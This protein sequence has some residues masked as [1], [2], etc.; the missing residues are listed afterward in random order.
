[1][2]WLLCPHFGAIWQNNYLA[3]PSHLVDL[4]WGVQNDLEMNRMIQLLAIVL[5]TT[6]SWASAWA[7]EVLP[8]TKGLEFIQVA[9]D[10][11]HFTFSNSGLRFVPW[12]FNYDHDR[13]NRLLETYWK[14]EWDTVVSDFQEMKA[15]GANTLR[16]HLQVSRFMKS[17][18]ELNDESLE[19]L[20][21]LV[22]LA[23]INGL[24]LDI[25]GLGCYDKKD[26]PQWYDNLDETRRWA[27]QARF[28]EAIAETCSNSPAIFCYDLMNEPVLSE[29]KQGRD[30]TPGAFSDRYFVQRIT[31]DFAGRSQ[32]EIAKAWVEKLVGAIRK[33]DKNHM[34][35]IG[36]I[37][38][39]LTWPGAKDVFYSKEVSCNLDFVSVHFYPKQREVKKALK[40]L[41]TYEI[42]KP[43]VIEEMFPLSCSVKELDKFIGDSKE[44]ATGWVG[45]YWGKTL[46]EYHEQ[47]S[48][49]AEGLTEDWLKYFVKKT[50]DILR[51]S[52]K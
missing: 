4:K 39:A 41:A 31:L 45:F 16:I 40:A 20:R 33:H 47:K 38:W 15:L 3:G 44:L 34:I 29:D 46:E 7:F 9:K 11:K 43:I 8:P 23:E 1:L 49:M 36:A 21:R 24:Y 35:T 52:R 10:R 18:E 32:K 14:A 13:S 2:P 19:L 6:G 5:L 48:G 26:V 22:R 25:T 50:P 37:P 51:R 27:V 30:W 17:A 12:G 28:W 42:G